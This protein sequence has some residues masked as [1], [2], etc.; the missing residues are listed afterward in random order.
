MT[1]HDFMN[2]IH[3]EC[4][5]TRLS[6]V[7]VFVFDS[8]VRYEYEFDY[9]KENIDAMKAVYLYYEGLLLRHYSTK[10]FDFKFELDEEGDF[11]LVVMEPK[12]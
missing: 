6:L 5:K 3:I 2:D 9:L 12:N 11:E 8:C 10:E 7:P 4:D 1:F